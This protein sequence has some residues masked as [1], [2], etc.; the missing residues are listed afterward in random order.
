MSK[1]CI[2]VIFVDFYRK[3]RFFEGASPQTEHPREVGPICEMW[4]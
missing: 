4:G 2:S 1:A 3:T